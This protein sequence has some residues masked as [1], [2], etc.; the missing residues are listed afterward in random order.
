MT[1]KELINFLKTQD[2]ALDVVY[3]MCSEYRLLEA[4]DIT[5][6][7]LSHPRPDGWV[8]DENI[9]IIIENIL[10]VEPKASNKAYLVLPGN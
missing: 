9:Y 8:H 3:E 10:T 7:K 4:K 1:V 5:T 2:Q 6:K